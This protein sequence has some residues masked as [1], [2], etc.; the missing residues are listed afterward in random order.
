MANIG[1]IKSI[2]KVDDQIVAIVQAGTERPNDETATVMGLAGL[3]CHPV[4]GDVV[5]WVDTGRENVVLA[6]IRDEQVAG[7]GE[8]ILFARDANDDVVAQLHL[9]ADGAIEAT[10]SEGA[11]LLLR[12]DGGIE[13]IT[14]GGSFE[15]DSGGTLTVNNGNLEVLP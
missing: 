13:G 2:S 4:P 14:D 11:Q 3:E 6:V 8:A 9:K 12:A 15:M 7:L 1:T 10:S 5:L